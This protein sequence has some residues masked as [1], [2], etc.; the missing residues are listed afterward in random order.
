MMEGAGEEEEDEHIPK[1]LPCNAWAAKEVSSAVATKSLE[2]D[3][4]RTSNV[5]QF[6]YDKLASL[7]YTL[8][9]IQWPALTCAV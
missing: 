1:R 4:C 5:A 3:P 8:A 2:T 9:A 6:L 7:D